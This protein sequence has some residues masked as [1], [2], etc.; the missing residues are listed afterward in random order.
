MLISNAIRF[1]T[2]IFGEQVAQGGSSSGGS[3]S[4]GSSVV[5]TKS[6]R[7]EAKEPLDCSNVT[8]VT[9]F[10][11]TGNEPADSARR[12]M[13]KVD[14]KYFKFL[15]G[16]L[17]EQSSASLERVLKYGNTKAQLDAL[18]DIPEFVGK[19]VYPVIALQAPVDSDFPSAKLKLKTATSSDVLSKTFWSA[20]YELTG[21]NVKIVDINA[22]I[23]CTGQGSVNIKCQLYHDNAWSNWL[24]LNEANNLPAEK[25]RFAFMPKVVN[26][27]SDSAQVDSVTVR[28]TT[29]SGSVN[30]DLT[31]IYTPRMDF[32]VPLQTAYLVVQHKR[33][34][35]STIEASVAFM[36]TPKHK[37]RISLGVATGSRESFSLP[38][39]DIDHATLAVFV[40]GEPFNDFEFNLVVNEITLNAPKDS[41]IAASYDYDVGSEVWQ[42]M[43]RSSAQQPYDNNGAYASRFAYSGNLENCSCAAMRIRLVR[44]TGNITYQRLGIAT[45]YRQDYLLPHKMTSIV[46]SN[47]KDYSYD[48]DSQL[49]TLVAPADKVIGYAGNF[50]GEQHALF[51]FAAGFSL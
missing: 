41:V 48:N 2:D 23:T 11:I 37:E 21:D 19:L 29:G 7:L 35:D 18:T 6:A 5:V 28:H 13:F 17:Y 25:I 26:I 27:G 50:I 30:G 4:S 33:L 43:T 46:V 12:F 1:G 44:T 34:I 8:S 38:D 47:T 51:G 45:G 15:N 31:E 3:S 16:Q 10:V 20:E 22:E 42:P 9:G 40:D 24:L 39:S 14:G 49:L 32:E 36:P